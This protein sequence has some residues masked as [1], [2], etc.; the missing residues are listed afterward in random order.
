MV[1][2][3]EGICGSFCQDSGVDSGVGLGLGTV[4]SS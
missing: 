2:S 1:R 3:S 4:F